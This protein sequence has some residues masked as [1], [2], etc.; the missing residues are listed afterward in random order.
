M[1]A[2]LVLVLLPI[3][4]PAAHAQSAAGAPAQGVAPPKNPY[5]CSFWDGDIAT[6]IPYF[7]FYL[8]QTL[9]GFAIALCALLVSWLLG[10]NQGVF[11]SPMVQTGF[12]VSLSIANLGFVLG[13]IIIAI[14]TILRNQTY[15]AKQILWK[16]V[17]MAI[18]VNFGLVIARPIV[19]ISDSFSNYFIQYINQGQVAMGGTATGNNGLAVALVGL[20]SPQTILNGATN[21]SATGAI[22]AAANNFLSGMLSM[23]FAIVLVATMIIALLALAGLLFVRYVELAILLILLPFAW[24]MWVFPKYSGEFSKWWNNFIKWAFFPAVAL[25]FMYLVII[26][27]QAK[28]VG[29]ANNYMNQYTLPPNSQNDPNN[30]ASAFLSGLNSGTP[31]TSNSASSVS[32]LQ[33]GLDDLVLVALMIGGLVAAAS[34]TGKAGG[35]VVSSVSTASK[36][37]ASRTSKWAG[38]QAGNAGKKT[39]R[40]GYQ[41]IGGEKINETLRSG[42]IGQAI[43]N[44]VKIPGV[45]AALGNVV[46]R[47]ASKLGRGLASV[48]K[49][50]EMVDEAKKAIRKDATP[51]ETK[52]ELASKGGLTKQEQ[53]ARISDLI[54]KKQLKGN[55]TVAGQ[56]IKT[57]MDSNADA[58]ERYGQNKMKGDFDK[59]MGSNTE[60]RQAKT[61]GARRVATDKFVEGMDKQDA[62]KMNVDARFGEDS[63]EATDLLASMAMNRPDLLPSVIARAKG[64]TQKEMKKMYYKKGGAEEQVNKIAT[65]QQQSAIQEAMA[66]TTPPVFEDTTK[67]TDV[68]NRQVALQKKQTDYQTQE[69]TLTQKR[70]DESEA[71][72]IHATVTPEEH[73]KRTAAMDA[74]AADL[75]KQ[76]DASNKEGADLA[77][78]LQD[79]KDQ[80]VAAR[81]AWEKGIL[82]NVRQ[83]MGA[84]VFKKSIVSNMFTT[85]SKVAA[86]QPQPP[87]NPNP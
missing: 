28:A 77:K 40:A 32:F 37:V 6:C 81:T 23:A 72:M 52:S 62:A 35:M 16:L 33:Q 86:A 48:S 60:M 65:T 15:G 49:N 55:E 18:L 25:F 34:L 79:I 14:M 17:V 20:F 59:V 73:A 4:G 85:A 53:F 31:N 58:I 61:P 64:K 56:D 5:S 27:L 10:F 38:K 63:D 76:R 29:Q 50:T 3:V 8:I 36:K 1:A 21:V 46:N 78:Q 69:D 13:I 26:T 7:L 75:A 12:S 80:G 45:G 74:E 51:A 47:G 67:K 41:A 24:L 87:P 83:A 19:A 42:R 66:S 68:Q 22:G 82:D 2:V 54:D 39:L 70:K 71:Y 84:D 43:Q 57:W 30:A 44:K 9:G 11:N